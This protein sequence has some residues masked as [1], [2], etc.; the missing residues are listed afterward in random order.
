MSAAAVEPAC[1]GVTL[2]YVSESQG[3]VLPKDRALPTLT[4][5][6]PFSINSPPNS[7]DA[8]IS[9]GRGTTQGAHVN[10]TIPVIAQK[11]CAIAKGNGATL[12]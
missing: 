2:S 9:F 10:G 6:Y 3:A 8:Y 11:T 7:F 12:E 4:I 5:V 1:K